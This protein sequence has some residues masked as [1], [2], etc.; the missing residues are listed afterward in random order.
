[1]RDEPTRSISPD[2]QHAQQLGLLAI[3]NVAD[4]V[5]EERAAVRQLEAADAIGLGVGERAFH[6]AEELALEHALRKRARVDSDQRALCARRKRMEG[7]RD[8]F[9]ARAVLAGDQDVGIRRRRRA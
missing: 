7:L 1:M 3:G 6:V 9:L 5:E 2:L 4:F 8:N